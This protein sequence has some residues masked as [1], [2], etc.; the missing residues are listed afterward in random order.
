MYNTDDLY[1]T[2]IFNGKACCLK[3]KQLYTHTHSPITGAF[4]TIIFFAFYKKKRVPYDGAC[5]RGGNSAVAFF[6][7]NPATRDNKAFY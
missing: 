2:S 7:Y 4:K 5:E 1:T 3:Q 6:F